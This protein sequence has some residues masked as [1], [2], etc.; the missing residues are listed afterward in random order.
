MFAKNNILSQ[1][2]DNLCRIFLTIKKKTNEILSKYDDVDYL[3]DPL[4]NIIAIANEYGIKVIPVEPKDINYEHAVL[5]DS[6]KNN[7]LIKVNKED[8]AEEQ[9]FSVAHE[10][11]HYFK[12][13]ADNLRKIDVFKYSDPSTKTALFEKTNLFKSSNDLDELAARTGD[14]YKEAVKIVKRTK[15]AERI[16]SYIADT[17]SKNLGKDV[18]IKK[19]YVALAKS[20]LKTNEIL[21]SSNEPFLLKII[22]Q[23]YDEEIADYF[24]ANILLPSERFRLWEHKSNRVIAKA[25]KVPKACVAKRRKEIEDEIFFIK[26][27]NFILQGDKKRIN[28][29]V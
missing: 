3:T 1:R 27:E 18:S 7:I 26:S 28:R 17:V 9:F 22:N 24:A 5:D 21:K 25:F 12:K 29:P 6:D 13:K 15:G 19:A 20:I 16:A 4:I 10:M 11:E 23:L 2:A 8:S 14:N